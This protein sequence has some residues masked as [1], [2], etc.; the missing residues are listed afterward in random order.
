MYEFCTRDIRAVEM[1][2]VGRSSLGLMPSRKKTRKKSRKEKKARLKTY[3]ESRKTKKNPKGIKQL[4]SSSTC[5]IDTATTQDDKA[6]SGHAIDLKNNG[7]TQKKQKG[8]RPV[9]FGLRVEAC[10]SI[11]SSTRLSSARQSKK[12]GVVRFSKQAAQIA[13][14]REDKEIA[15]LEKKLGMKKAKKLPTSFRDE[16]LDFLLEVADLDTTVKDFDED[17]E[18]EETGTS[19]ESEGEPER[20]RIAVGVGNQRDTGPYQETGIVQ[21]DDHRKMTSTASDSSEKE[22]D[23]D[24]DSDAIELPVGVTYVPPHLRQLSQSS[25]QTENFQKLHRVVRGLVNRLSETNVKLIVEEV[26]C[27]FHE[28]SRNDM[29]RT[30]TDCLLA[31]CTSASRVGDQILMDSI[32]LLGILH[33]SVGVEVGSYFV[34]ILAKKLEDGYEQDRKK[35]T[36]ASVNVVMLFAF[37][38]TLEMIHCRLVYDLVRKFV[39]SLNELDI[40]LLLTLLC[41]VGPQLRRDDPH[42]LKDIVVE[43]ETKAFSMSHEILDDSRVKFMLDTIMALKNNN[44]RKIRQYDPSRI[45]QYKQRYRDLTKGKRSAESQLRMGLS[46]LL[47]ADKCGRWW[48]VGSS[49]SGGQVAKVARLTDRDVTVVSDSKLV[50][51]AHRQRM[52]SDVKRTVF[53]VLM[54]SDDYLDAFEKLLKLN[55]KD[56]QAREIVHV[57]VDCCLQERVFNPFYAHLS[58]RLC[59]FSRSYQIT[60]Q[61]NVWDRL[62]AMPSLTDTNRQNLAKLLIHL[63]ITKALSMSIL[64][65]V[66]FSLLDQ[67]SVQFY[68]FLL[69]N[70]LNRPVKVFQAVFA[71]VSAVSELHHLREGLCVFM[72]HY[73]L[74]KTCKSEEK[75]KKLKEMV[76]LAE[77]SLQTSDK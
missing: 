71:R 60:F 25:R 63:F 12:H 17:T 39:A 8:K 18:V 1:N 3:F 69:Q 45:E 4:S 11:K 15:Q 29:N 37:L 20:K 6:G 31:S 67:P 62:K 72:R 57:V 68:T 59:Q 49:W 38:Y 24:M 21:S 23:D 48:V 66:D 51:L 44:L 77:K 52:T 7:E 75:K 73:V 54:S 46:D 33:N 40:E 56:K 50:T 76:G 22:E 35:P 43:V 65:V 30:L 5:G 47:N 2:Q 19:S 28:N 41:W 34:E 74:E 14:R 27:L 9:Q 10:V 53:C 42:A 55:L 32:L 70:L 36:K 16:G 13:N 61:Y 64:K 58:E 26:E